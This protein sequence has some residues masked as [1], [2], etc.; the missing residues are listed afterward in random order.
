MGA[1]SMAGLSPRLGS[2]LK[3]IYGFRKDIF[4]LFMPPLCAVCERALAPREAWLCRECMTDLAAGM[5]LGERTVEMAGGGP[6]RVVFP[7]AYTAAVARLVKDMKY[8]DRPG[9]SGVLVPFLA[10]ALSSMR[11]AA[12]VL[13]P[14]P[15]HAAKRRERGYNQSEL[16][17][18][19]VA[20]LTGLEVRRSALRR[21]RNTRAQA[22]L[23][24]RKRLLNTRQA[25]RADE[26]VAGNHV[27]LVDDVLTTGATLGEC[28]GA[29][30]TRGVSEVT[31]CV[32][33]SSA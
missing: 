30:R 6:M 11:L 17:A 4:R 22:G 21:L 28:A 12:P 8:S 10:M 16:L 1:E 3:S 9:L 7:L 13:V 18:D 19:G 2:G 15:L 20:R 27:I 5:E 25:F 31:G 32:V 29:L 33:A 23:E 14:V 26:S 24:G